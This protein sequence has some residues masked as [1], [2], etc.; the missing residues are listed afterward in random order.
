MPTSSRKAIRQAAFP[1]Q[2]AL[3]WT[4]ASAVMQHAVPALESL[5]IDQAA[6][7]RRRDRLIAALTAAGYAPLAPDGTFYLFSR[8]ADGSPEEIWD[9][10]ADRDVFVMPGSILGAPEH[11]R[12]SLT[13]SDAMI[14]KALPAFA[15]AREAAAVRAR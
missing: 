14:D 15:E 2:M 3:G 7:V 11:F 13:A 8:W 9:R 1:A 5:S 12:I 4:F 6:L 10:L